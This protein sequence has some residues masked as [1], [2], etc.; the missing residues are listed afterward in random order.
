M[1]KIADHIQHIADRIGK[2]Q[3]V[4][5]PTASG[6]RKHTDCFSVGIGSDYDGIESVP[7]GLEDVSKYPNLV[8]PILCYNDMDWQRMS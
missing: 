2:H 8:R 5:L 3:C 6:D 1:E 7:K 4:L